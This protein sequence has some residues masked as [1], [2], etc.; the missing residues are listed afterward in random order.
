[1]GYCKFF[2]K[3]LKTKVSS[4]V[5]KF[6]LRKIRNRYIKK[7]IYLY[8]SIL[9]EYSKIR[10]ILDYSYYLSVFII[11]L[12]LKFSIDNKILVLILIMI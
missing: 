2:P 12:G 9:L 6:M 4:T 5:N 1:M 10:A 3:N 11:N 8:L 7:A